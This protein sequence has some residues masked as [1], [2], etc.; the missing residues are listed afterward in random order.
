[1]AQEIKQNCFYHTFQL[2]DVLLSWLLHMGECHALHGM[3]VKAPHKADS[4]QALCL[5]ALM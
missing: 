5:K 1:M 4:L 3:F 2:V